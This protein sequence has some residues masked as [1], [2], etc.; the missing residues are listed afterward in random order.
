MPICAFRFVQDHECGNVAVEPNESQPD[1]HSFLDLNDEEKELLILRS[2]S[3]KVNFTE[4]NLICNYH[5]VYFLDG[6]EKRQRKCCNPFKI[7]R[8]NVLKYLHVVPLEWSQK[9]VNKNVF[10][11]PGEKLCIKCKIRI[12]Q[13]INEAISTSSTSSADSETETFHA[14]ID[15]TQAKHSLNLSL[16]FIEASPLQLHA[17][18]QHYRAK[19]AK[20][21][22]TSAKKNLKRKFSEALGVD[23]LES[24]GSEKSSTSAGALFKA[25]C[26]DEIASKI[27]RKIHEPGSSRATKIQLLTM[28]PGEHAWSRKAASSYF[29]VSEYLIRE[30]RKQEREFGVNSVP[31]PRQGKRLSEDTVA[32]IQKFYE[33]DDY[34]RI[35]PGKKD[36]V[37]VKGIGPVQKR[38]ILCNLKELY[39]SFKSKHNDVKVGFSKFASLRPKWCVLA[40]SS[41]T[42]SVWVC[43]IH[44]NPLLLLHA[45]QIEESYKDLISVYVCNDKSKECMLL[46]CQKC[47][48]KESLRKYIANKFEDVDDVVTFKQWTTVDRTEL[49]TQT[50]TVMEYIE[51]LVE[52]LIA[53]IPHSYIA[54]S[55]SEYFKHEKESLADN[56]ALIHMDFSEN[57]S[58]QIQHEA[59]GY[60][61]S[62]NSCTVHPAVLY[63]K[64]GQKILTKSLCFL[65]NDLVHDVSMVYVIQRYCVTV[66]K[67]LNSNISVVEY[68]TDGCAG[69]YKNRKS[70]YN[71]CK[72]QEDFGVGALWSFFATS[73]GKG[74]CDGVGGTVKRLIS[75]AS[76]QRPLDNQIINMNDMFEFC[77]DNIS[78]I[79]FICLSQEELKIARDELGVRFSNISPVRGT[80]S[81]HQFIPVSASQIATKIVSND[82]NISLVCNFDV[83]F[84]NNMDILP[85]SWVAAIYLNAWYVAKV[86]EVDFDDCDALLDFMHP[87]G[88]SHNFFWPS[89]SDQIWV[90]FDHI[91][92]KISPPVPRLRD[93]QRFTLRKA[94]VDMIKAKSQL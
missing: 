30:A 84:N 38:L 61:W 23:M 21:K 64:E 20:N 91:V 94:D 7:H 72:H 51:K 85:N 87:K 71:L 2:Q 65:S 69:Q 74:A 11:A 26:F 93:T 44:Q 77:K 31:P 42:H 37:S 25:S 83:S 35:M 53:L 15:G 18:P 66:F 19:Y 89:N 49:T 57:Y 46:K 3:H 68:F 70:F 6:F 10:V 92:C 29:E 45:A 41:G 58:F 22:Y 33:E 80:R 13:L 56:K 27:K 32:L 17:K 62:H 12:L 50:L 36:T 63:Y 60:H 88:P 40:G 4:N 90:P 79:H 28:I 39:Q 55:Q 24:S 78:G 1:F 73:H 59:Q 76:L 54:K 5:K 34:S 8:K 67:E 16:D 48:G 75:K 52:K 82:E 43:T 14:E 81:F 9:L 47:P 86:M